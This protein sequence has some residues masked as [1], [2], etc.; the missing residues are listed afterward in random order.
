MNKFK[1]KKFPIKKYVIQSYRLQI[2][3][4]MKFRN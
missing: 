1:K 3:D 2:P 4:L